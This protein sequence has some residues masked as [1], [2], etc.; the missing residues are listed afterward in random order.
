MT[1]IP[2]DFI[3]NDPNA[4][5]QNKAVLTT[6]VTYCTGLR[7][8]FIDSTYLVVV[9]GAYHYLQAAVGVTIRQA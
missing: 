3:H 2:S 1:Q 6:P 7:S 9:E 5:R 8:V 4:L